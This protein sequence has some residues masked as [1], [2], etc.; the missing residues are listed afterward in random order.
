MLKIN[1]T[2]KKGVWMSVRTP[3]RGC[4]GTVGDSL[5]SLQKSERFKIH[6]LNFGGAT[7]VEHK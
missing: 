3:T 1:N 7:K 6:T 2:L 5:E 4:S